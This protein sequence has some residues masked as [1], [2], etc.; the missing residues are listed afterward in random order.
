MSLIALIHN[1]VN[2]KKNSDVGKFIQN[3][4][5]AFEKL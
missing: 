2:M 3:V 1:D 4:S 5:Q